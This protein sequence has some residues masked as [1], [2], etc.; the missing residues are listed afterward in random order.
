MSEHGKGNFSH[1]ILHPMALI[2]DTSG[3]LRH[4]Y[5]KECYFEDA[6]KTVLLAATAILLEN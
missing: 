1:G 6:D 5:P 4:Q 3:I 2:V